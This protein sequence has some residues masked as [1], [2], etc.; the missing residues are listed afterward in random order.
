M[1]STAVLVSDTYVFPRA[2]GLTVIVCID[3][4]INLSAAVV[5]SSFG[6]LVMK[7]N[8]REG[9]REEDLAMALLMMI[10][11]NL[12]QVAYLNAQ[13][14]NC[15]KI[16]F[17]GNFLRHNTV[18]CRRLAFAIDYWSQG[19]MEALFL[20]HEGYFGALGT[21]L[22][23]AFDA[24]LDSILN[25]GYDEDVEDEASNQAHDKVTP[26]SANSKR[27]RSWTDVDDPQYQEA[28]EKQAQDKPR[29]Q[30]PSAS[31]R[32]VDSLTL[33]MNAA[34]K[35]WSDLRSQHLR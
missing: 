24:E 2:W 35:S 28:K 4:G 6:K 23:S 12:G 14:H 10:T 17:V 32:L 15:S 31:A 1:I 34:S 21:F 19:K 7:K 11:N 9:I 25:L 30:S 33:T 29:H 3:P 20:R 18:S 5:A 13:L 27:Q 26:K 22:E 8:P 16:F